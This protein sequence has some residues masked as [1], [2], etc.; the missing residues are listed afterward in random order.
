MPAVG[1][2]TTDAKT[3]WD[4]FEAAAARN[5]SLAIVGES[6]SRSMGSLF[7]Q[8][9]HGGAGLA[10]RGLGYGSRVGAFATT[11]YDFVL[12]ALSTWAAG[13]TFVSLPPPPLVGDLQVW[14]ARLRS[15]LDV[16]DVDAL[17]VSERDQELA[18]DRTAV[19]IG[20]KSPGRTPGP[21]GPSMTPPV[22]GAPLEPALCVVP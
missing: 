14:R 8:A 16:S 6:G 17:I 2:T 3:L 15:M 21:R 12:A 18:A 4:R 10:A 5:G 1:R 13:G 9:A 19:P 22:T 20:S 7:D 11:T